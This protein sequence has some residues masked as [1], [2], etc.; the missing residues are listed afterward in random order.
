MKNLILIGRG[1]RAKSSLIDALLTPQYGFRTRKYPP[2]EDGWS[3][4]YLHGFTELQ[5]CSQDQ[6]VGRCKNHH[7]QRIGGAFDRIG[8]PFLE[9]IPAGAVVV[10]DEL[11]FLEQ[12]DLLFQQAVFRL[13]DGDYRVLV[14][15]KDKD[16]PFLHSVKAHPKSQCVLFQ[17]EQTAA[18]RRELPSR[19][20][21]L[22]ISHK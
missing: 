20:P 5:T 9:N 18:L 14:S 19:F 22:K 1:S 16:N 11:G 12:D 17:A 3:P 21:W 15:M 7:S 4:I 2:A 6:L 13:L 8:V 10:L